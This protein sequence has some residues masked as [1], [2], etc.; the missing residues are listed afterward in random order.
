MVKYAVIVLHVFCNVYFDI[1]IYLVFIIS[2]FVLVFALY[3]C[4]TA[5]EELHFC[6]S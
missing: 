2:D 6:K 4:N 5:N 1:G 3:V